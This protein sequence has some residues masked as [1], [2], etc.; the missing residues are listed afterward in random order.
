MIPV[1]DFDP[2]DLGTLNYTT[3]FT[4]MSVPDT[5]ANA[6]NFTINNGS[7]TNV[8]DPDSTLL[9]N[10]TISIDSNT[11]Q[12]GDQLRLGIT[13]IDLTSATGSG[14]ITYGGTTFAYNVSDVSG[15]RTITF[16]NN[17]GVTVPLTD[18]E[19]LV[20]DL[21]YNSSSDDPNGTRV[22]SA[23][24]TDDDNLIS[25]IATFTVNLVG[26]NDSPIFTDLDNLTHIEGEPAEIYDNDVTLSDIDSPNFNGGFFEN[27]LSY[28]S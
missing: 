18:F 25:S 8:S 19:T 22:F 1:I 9:S 4:E 28:P 13:V 20:D 7:G 10:L 17:S 16:T 15:Q 11:I 27:L 12:T 3:T 24:V 23:T 5:G 6:V 2:T 14:T 26:V 21:K